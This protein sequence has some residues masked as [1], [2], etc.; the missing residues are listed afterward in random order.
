V[1]HWQ[2]GYVYPPV[3][4]PPHVPLD[5]PSAFVFVLTAI[6]VAALSL[7]R[8][9]N[10]LAALIALTP[11]A[12]AHYVGGT[13]ITLGKA[14]FLGFIIGLIVHRPSPGVL[15]DPRALRM[16]A[17]FGAV[18]VAMLLSFIAAEHRDAVVREIAK[19]LEYGALFGAGTIAFANDPDDRPI[20][21]ALAGATALVSVLAIVQEF[22]GA[23]SGV[24]VQGHVLPRIAGPLEGPN[25]LSGWLGIAIPFLLARVLGHRDWR[26]VTVLVLAVTAD[27]LSLSRSGIVA[28]IVGCAIVVL[29]SRPPRTVGLRF[30]G[31]AVVIAT[32]LVVL[33]LSVGLE[34]RFFSLAE[35]PQPD[36]LGTRAQLWRAAIDLW[37]TSPL[38]GV[39]AGNY[40]LDLAR[41]GLPDVRTHANSLYLQ[42]LAETGIIGLGAMLALVY[43]SIGTFARTLSRRPLVIGALG[44]SAAL[45]LHQVFDYLVFFPKIGE[46]WWLVL[47]IGAVEVMNARDDARPLEVAA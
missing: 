35:V 42:S 26:L 18:I 22:I 24:T 30:A 19:W 10:G 20:W 14:A 37:R 45:A 36:H 25:Q 28:A 38:V 39:G 44:A 47:A 9:A 34:A 12:F 1:I 7:K 13:S 15:R 4:Y 41:V 8:P 32:V 6:A 16:L 43:V 31:G 5:A 29:A 2:P 23:P 46:F 21:A 33:G 40:E 11:F 17:A 27:A 3:F